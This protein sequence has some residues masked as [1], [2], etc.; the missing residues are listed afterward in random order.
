MLIFSVMQT[1]L[2]DAMLQLPFAWNPM[3]EAGDFQGVVPEDAGLTPEQWAEYIAYNIGKECP[4]PKAGE[5][6]RIRAKGWPSW[7][8]YHALKRL[9][10]W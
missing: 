9:A 10:E 1:K 6:D 8:A 5:E 2:L 4:A 3:L 7:R